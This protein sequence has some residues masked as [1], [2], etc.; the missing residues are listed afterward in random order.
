M[1]ICCND[2]CDDED[3]DVIMKMVK[4]MIITIF[5]TMTTV[6]HMKDYWFLEKQLPMIDKIYTMINVS[7]YM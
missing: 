7:P 3:N 1:K 4:I 6:K 2:D 5:I